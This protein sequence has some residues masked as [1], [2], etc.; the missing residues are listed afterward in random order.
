MKSNKI[1]DGLFG[2]CV[3]DALG[4]P[5]QFLS[6]EVVNRKPVT[7][8]IG[9]GQFDLPHGSWSDDSSLTFCLA[10][11]LCKGYDIQDIAD[12]FIKWLYDGYWTPFGR[13]FDIGQSTRNAIERLKSGVDPLSSGDKGEY[14]NGNGS[15]MRILPLAYYLEDFEIK[16]R[17]EI[18]H[19]VSAITHA[20]SR[21]QVACGIY[22]QMCINLL[23]GRNPRDSYAEM[24]SKISAYYKTEPYKSELKYFSRILTEDISSFNDDAIRS[25]GYVIDTLEASLWCLLNNDSYEDTVLKAVNLGE[26]TDT[27][28]AVVGGLAGIYYGSDNIPK[29]WID[30]IVKKDEI[31]DLADRLNDKIYGTRSIR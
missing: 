2:L 24:K 6:R 12:K 31:A 19:Q 10:E 27:T 22:I 28:G 4:L 1:I 3:G 8:M 5:V 25:S 15:L 18:V 13:S 9:Y 16:K 21:S 17:F 26:D 7:D 20:H 11:S 23:K 30:M 14:N 29:K